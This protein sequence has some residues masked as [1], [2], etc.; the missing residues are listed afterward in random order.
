[1]LLSKRGQGGAG[2]GVEYIVWG[3]VWGVWSRWVCGRGHRWCHPR[4]NDVSPCRGV[5]APPQHMGVQGYITSAHLSE[6]GDDPGTSNEIGS[7]KGNEGSDTPSKPMGVLVQE[8]DQDPNNV[9]S[10]YVQH[11]SD[12]AR[13]HQLYKEEVAIM[14]TCSITASGGRRASRAWPCYVPTTPA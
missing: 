6:Q 4:T 11:P 1:M 10:H 8:E 3:F 2:E 13:S 12:P 5:R 7:D 9:V 14:A